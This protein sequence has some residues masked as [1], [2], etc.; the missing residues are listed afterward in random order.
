MVR[1]GVSLSSVEIGRSVA[2]E[3]FQQKG[4]PRILMTGKGQGHLSCKRSILL[5]VSSPFSSILFCSVPFSFWHLGFRCIRMPIQP[6]GWVTA[7]ASRAGGPQQPGEHLFQRDLF[8][9]SSSNSNGSLYICI[10]MYI[11]DLDMYFH[12]FMLKGGLRHLCSTI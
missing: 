1:A 7:D 12:I 6:S 2:G 5:F 8:M 9:S 10:Y 3:V 4:K 11:L